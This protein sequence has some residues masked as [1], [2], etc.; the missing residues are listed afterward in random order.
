MTTTSVHR[1]KYALYLAGVQNPR[2]DVRILNEVYSNGPGSIPRVLR[3]DFCGTGAATCEWVRVRAEN[4]GVG[5]DN[6]QE[7]LLWGH[8]HLVSNLSVC[9]RSRVAFVC[10]DVLEASC[11]ERPDVIFA[12][13]SS[14]C[15]LQTRDRLR[16]YIHQCYETAAPGGIVAIQLFAGP[17]AQVEGIDRVECDGFTYI[18]EQHSFNSVTNEAENYIHFEFPEGSDLWR[19]FS[20]S[21]RMWSPAEILDVFHES[22]FDHTIV[23]KSNTKQTSDPGI[24]Q[25]GSL[26]ITGYRDLY[27]VG[28]KP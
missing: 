22:G 20:Y 6:D 4:H 1:D 15:S 24:E 16:A 11:P 26:Y 25:C 3:E 17:E 9:E 23:Y 12:G 27:V 5:V 2:N 10:A 18:W 28:F 21:W 8:E 19:A 13:N 7:P 14:V